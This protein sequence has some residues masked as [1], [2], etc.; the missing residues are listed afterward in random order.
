ML[1]FVAGPASEPPT[2][3]PRMVYF[4]AAS[5]LAF[6]VLI[7]LAGMLGAMLLFL[8]GLGY[9]WGERRAWLLLLIASSVVVVI[10]GVF[11][12]GFAI[13]LPQGLFA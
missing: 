6:M 2:R 8:V 7:P 10:W 13:Q 3:T 5:L 12:K 11:V 9:L 4:T 1:L